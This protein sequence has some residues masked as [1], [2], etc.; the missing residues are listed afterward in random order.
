[1]GIVAAAWQEVESYRYRWPIPASSEARARPN[2]GTGIRRS[3][4]TKPAGPD[5][6]NFHQILGGVATFYPN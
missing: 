3:L 4:T 1:M 6:R 5:E 2:G